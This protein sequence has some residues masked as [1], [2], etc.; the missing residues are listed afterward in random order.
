MKIH[1]GV[2]FACGAALVLAAVFLR[3]TLVDETVRTERLPLLD[4]LG[5]DFELQSTFGRRVNVGEFRGKAVL[6]GFGFTHCATVCP[7]M[8]ARYRATLVEL[9]PEAAHVQPIFISLDPERD[10]IDVLSKYV[11]QFHPAIVGMTGGESELAEV[12]ARF[13]VYSERIAGSNGEPYSL[14]HSGHIYLLDRDG[15]VRATFSESESIANIAHAVRRVLMD[16]E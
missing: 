15:R 11:A 1:R 2:V 14:A 4:T 12:T 8:M 3:V 6:I 13:R 5:G 10:T 16:G 7:A 9:G